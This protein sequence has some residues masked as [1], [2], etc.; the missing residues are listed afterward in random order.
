MRRKTVAGIL[1]GTLESEARRFPRQVALEGHFA[2]LLPE[3]IWRHTPE[4]FAALAAKTEERYGI[5]CT[6][7][8]DSAV[9]SDG[10]VATHLFRIAQEAIT[11]AIKHGEAEKIQVSLKGKE[12]VILQVSNDGNKFETDKNAVS[13]MGLRIM[14][15]R[16]NLIGAGLKI[17]HVD[18]QTVV[19]CTVPAPQRAA[20]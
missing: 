11:N 16:A 12:A 1:A 6:F 4:Q 5:R 9:I 20:E 2:A 15:H 18:G 14:R 3:L 13:G 17:E 8:E 19:R 10:T 7:L